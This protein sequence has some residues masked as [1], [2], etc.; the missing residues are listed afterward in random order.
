[1]LVTKLKSYVNK[2]NLVY[3]VEQGYVS[4]WPT[5]ETMLSHVVKEEL[6]T[7][8]EEHPLLLSE[9]PFNDDASRQTLTEIVFQNLNFPCLYLQK[10]EVLS[11]YAVERTTGLV[12][13]S[14]EG[15][16]NAVPVY[17]GFAVPDAMEQLKLA[18]QDLTQFLFSI[19]R[20][21]ESEL[22]SPTQLENIQKIKENYCYVV[23]QDFDA[24]Y[25]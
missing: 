6:K 15:I 11:T 25:Q 13:N 19:L 23:R 1:M 10:Q 21:K 5:I 20:E 8:P 12:F 16:T 9:T 7:F 2:L 18:G 4:D 17:E 3:P 24:E 22:N 14:G